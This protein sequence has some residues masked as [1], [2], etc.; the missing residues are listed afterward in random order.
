MSRGELAEV[1]SERPQK[2]GKHTLFVKFLEF[3]V[4]HLKVN[5]VGTFTAEAERKKR[6]MN[7]KSS[8]PKLCIKEI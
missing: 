6:E 1:S 5:V 4:L 2:Y 7:K 3:Y 8:N